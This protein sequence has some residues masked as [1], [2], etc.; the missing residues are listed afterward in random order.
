ML[1]QVCGQAPAKYTCPK[2]KLKTC[3]LNCV[4]QHKEGGKCDGMKPKTVFVPAAEMDADMLAKDCHFLDQINLS[5]ERMKDLTE[6]MPTAKKKPSR[7]KKA[8]AERGITMRYLPRASSRAR[9]NQTRLC[10][11][12]E[13]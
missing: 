3:S 13:I 11:S 9:E 12:Q 2:C 6:R 1:C 10:Q 7:L 8:C 4:K 5:K